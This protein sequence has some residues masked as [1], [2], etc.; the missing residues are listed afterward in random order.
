MDASYS[1]ALLVGAIQSRG[2]SR[3]EGRVRADLLPPPRDKE[4]VLGILMLQVGREGA[5]QG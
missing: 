2:V 5:E 3:S 4:R 1:T